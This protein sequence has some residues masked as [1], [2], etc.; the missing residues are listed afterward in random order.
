LP[1]TAL[2]QQFFTALMAR[3]QADQDHTSLITLIEE[4]A[5]QQLC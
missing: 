3:N 4:M 1:A 5:Q 2:V